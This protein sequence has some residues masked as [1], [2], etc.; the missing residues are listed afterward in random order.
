MAAKRRMTVRDVV[1]VACAGAL[2]VVLGAN[3][4]VGESSRSRIYDERTVP[5]MQTAL[6]FGAGVEPDGSPSAMLGD[7]L[8]LAVRLYRARK[9]ERILL[10]A[11]DRAGDR[12]TPAMLARVRAAGIPR[13]RVLL[14]D[15]GFSTR[16]SCARART[17]FGLGSATLVTQSYHLPRALFVCRELGVDGVGVGAPDWGYY[18]IATMLPHTLREALATT[19]AAVRAALR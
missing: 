10:S 13:D 6:V 8:D 4:V 9:V 18:T 2:L 17:A 3:A 16:D 14:D 12:E 1:R 7:R 5:S 15:R 11:D 19:S